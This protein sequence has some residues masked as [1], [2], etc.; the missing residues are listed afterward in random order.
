MG[1]FLLLLIVPLHRAVDLD[2]GETQQVELSDGRKVSVALRGVNVSKDL[3]R[4][5]V[6]KAEVDVTVDGR[7]VSLSC[8]NYELPKRAADVQADCPITRDYNANTTQDHWRLKKAARIRLWPA[9]SPWIQPGTFVYP[10]KQKWF[11]TPTQMSNEPTYV[12]G[13]ENPA[14]KKIYYHSGLDIGGAEGL[15]DIVAATD[16]I[17][18]SSGLDVMP[19]HK[20]GTPAEPRYD[21]VYLMD[22]RGW[23]YRYSHLFS[24]DAAMKPG[25]RVKMG[26][27]VGVLGKEGGSGGWSHLHF[28]IKAR[29]PS[30]EWGTEEGY[31]FL[32]ESYQREHR[33]A[34]IAVARPHIFAR[35][36]QT[37]NLDASRSWTRSGKPKSYEWIFS[38]GTRATGPTVER[39][40]D[41]PGCYSEILRVTDERG[42]VA[43]DF[44]IVQ[45]AG[46]DGS[47]LPPS[48]HASYAPSLNLRP[49]QPI[50]FLVRSFR[51]THGSEVWDFG[52]GTPPVTVKSDGNV[53]T[54]A[55][56][57][58][59]RT[60]HSFAKAGR[61]LVK[62]ERANERGEKATARLE[63][64]ID[65]RGGN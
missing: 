59:A 15:V 39:R 32:W 42:Q 30:G 43:H 21:V 54:L 12:D 3:L 44:A 29:Q 49:N 45:V 8:G 48:I 61:Y 36:G 33:P 9:G 7:P 24:I 57:G 60:T 13:G 46:E 26:Q 31:A 1:F 58:Y 35:A 53:K 18:V 25:A 6:R 41:K 4:Q 23:Y 40:Y 16:G 55:K 38:D 52:D 51:T 64:V 37:V 27:K 62:V 65:D 22:E 17:V 28:E 34:I 5:A 56:D 63:V 14:Q 2:P 19:E 50:N 20:T 47:P 10:A 11:A